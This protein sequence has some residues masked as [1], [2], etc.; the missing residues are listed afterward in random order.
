GRPRHHPIRIALRGT[1]KKSSMGKQFLKRIIQAKDDQLSANAPSTSM[2][3]LET[4]AENTASSLLYL[5]LQALGI[6]DQNADHAA[7]HI[8]KALGI[9]T[10]VRGIPYLVRERQLC[11]PTQLTANHGLS[12]EDLFRGDATALTK[13]SDVVFD[14][15]TG[16]ND[17]LLRTGTLQKST[18]PASVP[19]RLS[20]VCY[21]SRFTLIY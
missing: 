21:F 12:S 10:T 4:Y 16:E 1:V 8:G 9:A 17:H 6:E 20:A 7:S 2:K 11:L 14:I 3:D 5:Q 18:L 19:A 15:A 13:L